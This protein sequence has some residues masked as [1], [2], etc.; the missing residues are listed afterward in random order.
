MFGQVLGR[1]ELRIGGK[2]LEIEINRQ[3]LLKK[4]RSTSG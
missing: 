2:H 1:E 4:R 3:K